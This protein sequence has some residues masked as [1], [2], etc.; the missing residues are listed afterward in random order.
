MERQHAGDVVSHVRTVRT[1]THPAA[2]SGSA[3]DRNERQGG[4]ARQDVPVKDALHLVGG[5]NS[6]IFRG[7]AVDQVAATSATVS[8]STSGGGGGS[9]A[10]PACFDAP[11]RLAGFGSGRLDGAGVGV[12]DRAPDPPPRRI[13]CRG[14]EDVRADRHHPHP[15]PD[16][17]GVWLRVALELAPQIG[18]VG[19]VITRRRGRRRRTVDILE[20]DE[21]TPWANVWANKVPL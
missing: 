18:N 9:R 2:G 20:F 14:W 11:N 4:P 8:G 17:L 1:S 10:G 7:A 6:S 13:A 19:I 5:A 12:A 16:Q 3:L 15:V 21:K